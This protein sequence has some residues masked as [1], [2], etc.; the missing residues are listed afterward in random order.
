VQ[1]GDTLLLFGRRGADVVEEEVHQMPAEAGLADV[2][3]QFG[4][5]QSKGQARKNG[6]GGEIPL[7]WSEITV[8]KLKHTFWIWKPGE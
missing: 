1:E 5:F 7:G 4:I 8:G 2:L 3:V 6:W